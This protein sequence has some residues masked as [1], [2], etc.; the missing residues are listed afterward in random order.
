MKPVTIAASDNCRQCDNLHV[1]L[2]ASVCTKHKVHV[3]AVKLYAEV[4]W[5]N[6][7]ETAN[8]LQ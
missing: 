3:D 6:Q 2:T 1:P 8:H 5:S 7:T 4:I